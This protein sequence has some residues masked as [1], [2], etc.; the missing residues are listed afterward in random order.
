MNKFSQIDFKFVFLAAMLIFLPGVEALKNIFAFLFVLSW[1]F[2]VNKENYWGGKWRVIDTIFLLWLLADASVSINAIITHQLPGSGFRD[3]FRYVLIAWIISR[4][5]FL[6]EKINQLTLIVVIA[7][8][9]TLGYSYYS[10]GG[11]L[12]ELHSVGHIN[13]TAIFLLMT[14]SIALPLFLFDFH[15]L[16][17]YQRAILLI[18]SIILF[19]STIDTNSRASFGILIIITLLNFFFF[20]I[21]KKNISLIFLFLTLVL[22]VGSYFA[23][24]PPKALKRI[25]NNEHIFKDN[26]REKINNFS[27]YVFKTYPMLGVGFGNYSQINKLDIEEAVLQDLGVYEWNNY[28][29]SSH[30]HNLYYSF[31]VSGG[32]VIF[33]I[34]V[35][36]WLSIFWIIFELIKVREN[37]WIVMSSFNVVLIN[38]GI[39]FFNTT[40]HHE[41]AILSM[42]VLGLLIS[43]YRLKLQM[44]N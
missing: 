22:S 4:T 10:T 32:L 20:N 31:L 12:K 36:F 8:V 23:Y 6:K 5:Y 39:G 33:S 9:V 30:A 7:T 11:M 27:Y 2:F 37:H 13:H 44:K 17:R 43:Q 34:F 19:L 3:V 29:E 38:L 35:M 1:F 24:N 42:F 40:L 25:Q 14:Y 21:K 26:T 18:S 41:H 15:K 28:M 16:A